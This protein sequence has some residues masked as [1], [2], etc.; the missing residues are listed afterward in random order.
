MIHPRGLLNWGPIWKQKQQEI[1]KMTCRME[2]WLSAERWPS[3]GRCL[4][5]TPTLWAQVTHGTT[6][7][8][9]AF[10]GVG[11]GLECDVS[12]LLLN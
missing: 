2:L 10:P 9:T 4:A 11:V 1:H 12:D 6:V 7:A 5:P 8:L 3:R